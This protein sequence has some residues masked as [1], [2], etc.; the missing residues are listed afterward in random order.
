METT[1]LTIEFKNL[2]NDKGT[3]RLALFNSKDGYPT[4]GENAFRKATATIK[5]KT[6]KIIIKNIPVGNY[7]AAVLHDENDNNKM[8]FHFYGAPK[9]GYG[10]SNDAKGSFGPPTYEDAAFKVEGKESKIIINMR[11]F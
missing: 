5:D 6:G 1:D 4:K 3:I 7:A 9:E 10:A 2:R 11:Y 8:D